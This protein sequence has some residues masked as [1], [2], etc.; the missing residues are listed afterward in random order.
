VKRKFV[1]R[2]L[3]EI[4]QADHFLYLGKKNPAA[5]HRFLDAMEAALARIR[6]DPGFG[7]KLPLDGPGGQDIRFYRPKGFDA[8]VILYRVTNDALIILRVLHGSQDIDAAIAG[9]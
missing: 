9:E 4:E 7:A 8:Y 1:V 2:P 5:A 3:A 6:K